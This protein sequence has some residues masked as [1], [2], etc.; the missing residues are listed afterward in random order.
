[1]AE[2]KPENY[3]FVDVEGGRVWYREN[4][5]RQDDKPSM[6]CIHGGPGATHSYMLPLVDLADE[7]RVV[8]YDQLDAGNSDKPGDPANWQVER[9]VGEVIALRVA[10]GLDRVVV[11]GNSWGGSVAAEY[12]ITRPAGLAGVVLSSPVLNAPRWCAD[13]AAYREALPAEVRAVLD[14]HEAAGTTDSDAYGKAALMFYRRHLCRMN[15]WPG[16][17]QR[18]LDELNHDCYG[19]MWGPSEFSCTGT[20]ADY[21]CSER[22]QDIEVP[23]LFT[24]GEYDEAT[25]AACRDFAAMLP[26]AEVAVF[27]DASHFTFAEKRAEYIALMRDF[28]ARVE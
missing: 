10:L 17:V 1:M 13:N 8:F 21:D 12:A 3:G 23:T 28:I 22:L 16:Y 9:F 4:G 14:E 7:Y 26:G 6:L 25:P 20:L 27:D 15:P 2:V 24:C 5:A 19:T 11:I 18:S